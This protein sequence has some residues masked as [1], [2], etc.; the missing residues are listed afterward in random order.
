MML[1]SESGEDLPD[2]AAAWFTYNV[3]DK[4]YSHRTKI[5]NE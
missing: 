2:G 3:A 1:S 4:Q 5:E